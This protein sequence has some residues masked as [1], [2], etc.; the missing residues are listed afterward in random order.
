MARIQNDKLS[1]LI[2][3]A[4]ISS[5]YG[6]PYIRSRPLHV[7]NP[8][9]P[10]QQ[11]QRSKFK[12]ATEFVSRNLNSLIRPYWNPEARRQRMTGQNLFFKLN[13]HA[14]D[15]NGLAD[16]SFLK[17]VTGN[18][19]GFENLEVICLADDTIELRWTNNSRDSKTNENNHLI[20]F[21]CDAQN[22]VHNL[23]C[24]SKRK[25]EYCCI[26]TDYPILFL[27]FWNENLEIASEYEWV[28]RVD[29][30]E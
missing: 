17:P 15:E 30:Y 25:D 12:A 9:T 14:F 27:F 4:I 29:G 28:K 1:G 20:V 18:L 23:K 21:G 13:I 19:G 6:K 8:K 2:G 11:N 16:L 5:R 24:N 3:N 10:A 22:Y 26:Q 7:K